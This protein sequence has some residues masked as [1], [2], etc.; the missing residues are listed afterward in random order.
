MVRIGIFLAIVLIM[1]GGVSVLNASCVEPTP[2][3]TTTP[4][5]PSA[6]STS[7]HAPPIVYEI[8]DQLEALVGTEASSPLSE[9]YQEL[10]TD[11]E[12]EL[13]DDPT[14]L[15]IR[16]NLAYLYQRQVRYRQALEQYLMAQQQAPDIADP[17][18]GIGRLYYDLALI[19]MLQRELT[20]S[21]PDNPLV[22]HPDARTKEI[23]QLAKEQLLTA[24]NLPCLAKTGPDG[25]KIYIS[26]PDTADRFLEMIESHLQLVT[27]A[28]P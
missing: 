22:F 15:W 3:P 12:K 23:L 7:L 10:A 27:P 8:I 2:T 25:E 19:D 28:T 16:L 17:Y 6:D 5:A 4:S 9:V 24:K 1:V 14:N 20:S 11:L 21:S 13:R 18:I 26:P